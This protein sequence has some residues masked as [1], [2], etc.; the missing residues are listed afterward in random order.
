MSEIQIAIAA[1]VYLFGIIV[2]LET[3]LFPSATWES[4]RGRIL[5]SVQGYFFFSGIFS[6]SAFLRAK[7]LQS[8]LSEQV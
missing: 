3:I 5:I 6:D 8:A 2:R 1:V 4:L 7:F